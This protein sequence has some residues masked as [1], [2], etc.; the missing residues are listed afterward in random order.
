MKILLTSL[1][2]KYIHTSLSI[3][4]LKSFCAPLSHTHDFTV[5]EY[6]I[7][8]PVL[9]IAGEI[10]REKADLI[11]FSCY[12]WNIRPTLEICQVL[13]KVCP[14]VFIV[15]GGPEVSF[16]AEEMMANHSFVDCIVVGEGEETFFELVQ[17]REQELSLAH[18]AGLVWRKDQAVFPNPARSLIKEL[19]RIPF[20]YAADDLAQFAHKIVYYE[21]SR[22]CPFRCQYC[23]SSTIPGVRYFS[24]DRVKKDLE[25]LIRSG[26]RQV[27]FVDR[28]FNCH[29]SRTKDL[30]T[31]LLAY[32]DRDLN[33]HF[34][35][36]ADLLDEEIIALLGQAPPGYFQVEI[37]V[38][39]TNRQV[40]KTIQREMDFAQVQASVH[41]LKKAGNVHLHLDL[42][43][44]L[45]GENLFSFE[46]SF[47][48]VYTLGPHQLQLGFL[49]LLKG[50]GLRKQAEEFGLIYRDHPPYEVLKTEALSFEEM[51]QLRNIEEVLEQYYNSGK[52]G[53]TLTYAIN[54]FSAEP[55]AFYRY[56]AEYLAQNGQEKKLGAEMRAKM[57]F[58]FLIGILPR[59]AE[60]VILDLIKLDWLVS[61]MRN[62]L[63]AWL[64]GKSGAGSTDFLRDRQM[65]E[66]YL[67][68]HLGSTM[69]E[70]NKFIAVH[71]FQHRFSFQKD[72]IIGIEE[73]E[74]T[75]LF[76]YSG[77]KG[78]IQYPS[79]IPIN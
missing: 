20:P 5:R 23:L 32:Q 40:L 39:S 18:T 53:H 4:Y 78:R 76:D 47:N 58:S 51:L 21:S 13:K 63:P 48:D 17:C 30:L 65:R 54:N 29:K 66:R 45:P 56:F 31:F 1:N 9:D 28:T 62:R 27:K 64:L 11:G 77:M 49:K 37:G 74:S 55:F 15:L 36:A 50:S 72:R 24:L 71:R 8:E 14:Q 60:P 6:S 2:A 12:I 61:E 68:Q 43:A 26:I 38:Q 59:R 16:D 3:Y 46:K 75:L 25:K 7:N 70:I 79:I 35:I 22:G 41:Q 69:K 57:L 44:G 10:Y 73:G 42:I 33:F 19:D 52:Y 34:E 67:P